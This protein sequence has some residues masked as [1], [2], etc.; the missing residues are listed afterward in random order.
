M[1][2]CG[3]SA[4]SQR[5]RAAA[6]L[7]A[8]RFHNASHA[9]TYLKIRAGL[10]A[11]VLPLSVAITDSHLSGGR[12]ELPSHSEGAALPKGLVGILIVPLA[13]MTWERRLF[14]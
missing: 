13:C 4:T 1:A 14:S 7:A 2:D 5:D 12:T 9:V 10:A 3:R 8:S 11:T 6:V